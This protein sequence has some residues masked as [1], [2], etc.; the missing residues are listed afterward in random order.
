MWDFGFST[1]KRHRSTREIPSN[2]PQ[3]I[4]LV[5]YA[6]GKVLDFSKGDVER[7]WIEVKFDRPVD[8]PQPVRLHRKES[9]PVL[10]PG[11][12][13]ISRL[14]IPLVHAV[15]WTMHMGPGMTLWKVATEM[16]W[17]DRTKRMWKRGQMYMAITHVHE[18]EDFWLV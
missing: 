12:V 9:E 4:G 3:H 8:I 17:G 11:G 1:N 16:I 15:V 13:P 10:G 5:N 7:T 6:L 14:Q 18:L 2:K